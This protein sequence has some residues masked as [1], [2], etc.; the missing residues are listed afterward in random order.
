MA[1]MVKVLLFEI[2]VGALDRIG[3]T[4]SIFVV[5]VGAPRVETSFNISLNSTLTAFSSPFSFSCVL[6]YETFHATAHACRPKI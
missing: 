1:R 5:Q 3:D 6:I 4:H 2:Y